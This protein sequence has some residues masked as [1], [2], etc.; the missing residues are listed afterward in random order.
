MT[1]AIFSSQ[2]LALLRK[3][4]GPIYGTQKRYFWGIMI[5]GQS[6]ENFQQYILKFCTTKYGSWHGFSKF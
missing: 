1:I 6:F 5:L 4:Q 2:I 3:I